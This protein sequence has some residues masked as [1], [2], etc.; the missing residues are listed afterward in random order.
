MAKEIAKK[1]F[2]YLIYPS[3]DELREVVEDFLA[4]NYTE[5][6]D[7]MTDKKWNTYYKKN[8]AQTVNILIKEAPGCLYRGLLMEDQDI[9]NTYGLPIIF[10]KIA[11]IVLAS[12]IYPG[13]YF[14]PA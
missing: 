12:D 6:Y 1:L 8:I 13:N 4:E 11:A 10:E 2:E 9:N 7:S 14:L 3:E 5:F